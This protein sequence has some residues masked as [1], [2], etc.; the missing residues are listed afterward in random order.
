MGFPDEGITYVSDDY[1]S[2]Y[3]MQP[4]NDNEPKVRRNIS[5]HLIGAKRELKTFRCHL[6]RQ[7]CA[8]FCQWDPEMGLFHDVK[9]A[10]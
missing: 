8:L 7:Q 4:D 9:Q 2:D 5:C 3:V 10:S 6:L 1:T